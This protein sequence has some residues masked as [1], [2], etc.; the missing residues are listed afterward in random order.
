MLELWVSGIALTIQL[1]IFSL[2]FGLTLACLFTYLKSINP[3]LN[4]LV[5][6]YVVIIRGV[7]LL[8]QF[9]LV[10]Y[11][12]AQFAWIRESMFWFILQ[13]PFFCAIIALALNSTAYTIVLLETAIGTLSTGDIEACK[14]L[15]M[16]LYTRIRWVLSKKVF[17]TFWPTYCNEA[18][19][20]LKSTALASSITLLDLMGTSRRIMSETY[21]ISTTLIIVS[22]CYLGLTALLIFSFSSLSRFIIARARTRV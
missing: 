21:E 4:T 13:K 12:L 14:V 10:Y 2:A 20:I 16:S 6:S 9:F 1:T 7:P 22:I 11:G 17:I 5:K 8:V 15:H 18:I 19:A 3:I